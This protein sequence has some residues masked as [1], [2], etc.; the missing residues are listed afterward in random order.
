MEDFARFFLSRVL[1]SLISHEG[2]FFSSFRIASCNSNQPCGS[3][4][5]QKRGFGS[6]R[7]VKRIA[8]NRNFALCG[9]LRFGRFAF[10]LG[11]F[12]P[13][14]L[15]PFLHVIIPHFG[16]VLFCSGFSRFFFRRAYRRFSAE[17]RFLKNS[18]QSSLIW[19]KPLYSSFRN[20]L[21]SPIFQYLLGRS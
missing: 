18:P 20:N 16:R 9:F 21:G 10:L 15:F 17:Q 1:L 3:K 19:S 4:K 8:K 12:I 7:F 13:L 14:W 6:R 11:F 5:K 2:C